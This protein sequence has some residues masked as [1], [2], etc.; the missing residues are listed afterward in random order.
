M[1]DSDVCVGRCEYYDINGRSVGSD[2]AGLKIR[3]ILYSDGT[4]IVD[5]IVR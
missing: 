3:R 1:L 5:K 2:F 4:V